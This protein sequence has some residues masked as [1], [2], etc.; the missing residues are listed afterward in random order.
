MMEAFKNEMRNEIRN[1]VAGLR[2]NSDFEDE[3][4]EAREELEDE[5][6]EGPDNEREERFLR[7]VAQVSKV[8]K[9][10]VSNFFET[11]NLEDLFDWIGELEDYFKF[12]D[13]KDPQRAQLE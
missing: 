4:E 10:K 9:V 13:I 5:E 12:E 3:Y 2:R 11:L 1:A 6:A 8:R 7:A